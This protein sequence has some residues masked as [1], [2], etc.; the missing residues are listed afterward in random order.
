MNVR[1]VSN[2]AGAIKITPEMVAW[3]RTIREIEANGRRSGLRTRR[4]LAQVS[5]RQQRPA[6]RLHSKTVA[7]RPLGRRPRAGAD[8]CGRRRD[9]DWDGAEQARKAL[10]MASAR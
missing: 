1:L 8:I 7:G 10:D 3:Y 6:P 5:H 2:A 9:C 4:P